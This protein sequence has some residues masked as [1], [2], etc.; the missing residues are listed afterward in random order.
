[1]WHNICL[2]KEWYKDT[3]DK[4]ACNNIIWVTI[5]SYASFNNINPSIEY[6]GNIDRKYLRMRHIIDIIHIVL[7][8]LY[9]SSLSLSITL[10]QS[11]PLLFTYTS[12]LI[13]GQYI[14]FNSGY[15]TEKEK[16]PWG[17][18]LEFQQM[19]ICKF[20]RSYRFISCMSSNSLIL[21]YNQ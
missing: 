17:I 4:G 14:Q 10:T 9:S 12:M 21:A 19:V 11:L 2:T 8:S 7:F 13:R 15:T 5:L 1:M 18:F 6:V 20:Y 16:P 3:R